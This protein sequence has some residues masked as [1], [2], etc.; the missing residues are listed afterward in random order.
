[1]RCR[2]FGLSRPAVST[3]IPGMRRLRN[4]ESH[5]A[6]SEPGPLPDPVLA[7]LRNHLWTRNYSG[8]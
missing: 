1:M 8:S 4:V 7:E 5:C 3:V 2:T 6:V